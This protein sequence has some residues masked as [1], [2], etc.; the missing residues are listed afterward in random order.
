MEFKPVSNNNLVNS[1]KGKPIRQCYHICG[2]NFVLSIYQ[3]AEPFMTLRQGS[4]TTVNIVTH[5]SVQ[6]R[7]IQT[8]LT[9][10][11]YITKMVIST[12]I[13]PTV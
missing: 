8:N 10:K 1:P 3:A 9:M 12:K 6:F 13:S 11:P 7:K 5:F 4:R 2:R